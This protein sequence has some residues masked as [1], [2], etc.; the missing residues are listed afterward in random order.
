LIPGGRRFIVS[1]MGDGDS[2]KDKSENKNHK[3]H[4]TS[5]Q[6]IINSN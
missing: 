1:I 5:E 4:V 2:E 3:S 6:E